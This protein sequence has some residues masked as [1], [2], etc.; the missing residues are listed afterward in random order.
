MSRDSPSEP[1][2]AQLSLIVRRLIPGPRDVVFA[3]WTQPD[4]LLQWWGP[5][6]VTLAAA[7]IDL[8]VGGRYQLVNQFD[9]GS[10]LTISGVF[11][12][13]EPPAKL[14]YT[15]A[16]EPIAE[17]TTRTR[18][19]VRFEEHD[20]DTEVIVIHEG[21][22]SMRSRESNRAG[23]RECLEGLQ[24]RIESHRS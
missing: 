21:F 3:A 15:W 6:G 17:A 8:Q 22:E 12:H 10:Q 24:Q 13:I 16:H 2:D 11:E 23:W 7:E 19:T 14:V 4:R 9:D 20:Q 5:R 1:D 18:V